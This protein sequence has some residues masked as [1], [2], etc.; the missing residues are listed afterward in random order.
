MLPYPYICKEEKWVKVLQKGI[1]AVR[2]NTINL[3]KKKKTKFRHLKIFFKLFL[4]MNPNVKVDI[5]LS[6]SLQRYSKYLSII[7]TYFITK[8]LVIYN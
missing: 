1:L 8:I 3:G 5:F 7:P 2:N 4:L 6:D